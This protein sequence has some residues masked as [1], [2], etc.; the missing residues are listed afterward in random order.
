MKVIFW[1]ITDDPIP[2]GVPDILFSLGAAGEEAEL[3]DVPAGTWLNVTHPGTINGATVKPGDTVI[4]GAT[5]TVIKAAENIDYE[6]VEGAI[7]KI[8]ALEASIAA[9]LAKPF[10]PAAVIKSTTVLSQTMY[11]TLKNRLVVLYNPNAFNEPDLEVEM[12]FESDSFDGLDDGD[13]IY[14]FNYSSTTFNDGSGG[15]SYPVT[16]NFPKESIYFRCP[17]GFRAV[18]PPGGF[19]TLRV[20]KDPDATPPG[21]AGNTFYWYHMLYEG[22]MVSDAGAAVNEL[23]NKTQT[24]YYGLAPVSDFGG[25]ISA[26]FSGSVKAG[27]LTFTNGEIERNGTYPAKNLMVKVESNGALQAYV[28]DPVTFTLTSEDSASSQL[29]KSVRAIDSEY[30]AVVLD[31]DELALMRF[32]GGGWSLLSTCGLIVDQGETICGFVP[33]EYQA[34]NHVDIA[35]SSTLSG[36]SD[37]GGGLIRVRFEFGPASWSLQGNLSTDYFGGQYD[38]AEVDM[39]LL[40]GDRLAMA[41]KGARNDQF[42]IAGWDANS[43]RYVELGKG[44]DT[45]ASNS[46][47]NNHSIYMLPDG[48]IAITAFGGASGHAGS[49]VAREKTESRFPGSPKY[50]WEVSTPPTW[51]SSADVPVCGAIDP[52]G[53]IVGYSHVGTGAV[54]VLKAYEFKE[55]TGNLHNLAAVIPSTASVD[56]NV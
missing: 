43:K 33:V 19:A 18:L 13:V 52:L 51:A 5:N 46:A 31:T 15:A 28:Y 30:Y 6:T 14:L 25:G 29:V 26:P 50:D 56:W 3:P 54:G 17:E 2:A 1:S 11:R 48:Q 37:S 21:A 20:V 49:V 4:T 32:A 24:T 44:P 22:P 23:P 39:I 53:R 34:G 10:S 7:A 16:I 8:S 41:V 42:Y 27:S 40:P 9:E 36:R 45:V 35:V 55:T 38:P 12:E 47:S